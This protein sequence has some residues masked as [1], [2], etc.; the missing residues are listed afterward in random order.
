MTI[1][2]MDAKALKMKEDMNY[3]CKRGEGS[4]VT[5]FTRKGCS[6]SNKMKNF[7]TENGLSYVEINLTHYPGTFITKS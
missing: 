1:I 7:M 3:R 4:Q 2:A 5:I 6:E